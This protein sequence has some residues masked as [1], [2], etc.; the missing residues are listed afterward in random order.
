MLGFEF[1]DEEEVELGDLGVGGL[2]SGGSYALFSA[3]D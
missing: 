1:V 2:V 3:P